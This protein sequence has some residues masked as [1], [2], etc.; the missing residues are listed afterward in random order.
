MPAHLKRNIPLNELSL[1]LSMPAKQLM[2]SVIKVL[3]KVIKKIQNIKVPKG[4]G[5]GSQK[6]L[7]LNTMIFWFR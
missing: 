7:I 6:Y 4:M 2:A 1:N 5:A 3:V